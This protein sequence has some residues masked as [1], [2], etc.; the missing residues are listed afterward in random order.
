MN[1]TD[2]RKEAIMFTQP[3]GRTPS[4]FAVLKS[5]PLAKLP[6]AGKVYSLQ[7][8]G[9][10]RRAEVAEASSSRCSRAR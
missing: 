8:D 6:E 7:A 4:T 3:Y 9:R 2:K 10:R 5:S 1:I